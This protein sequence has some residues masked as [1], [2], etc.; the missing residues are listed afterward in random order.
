MFACICTSFYLPAL[1]TH[2]LAHKRYRNRFESHADKN[3]NQ[4]RADKI[5]KKT[6]K[7]FANNSQNEDTNPGGPAIG[8]TTAMHPRNSASP[9]RKERTTRTKSKRGRNEADFPIPGGGQALSATLNLRFPE[10]QSRKKQLGV[11]KIRMV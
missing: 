7:C 8:T 6:L 10:R 3:K 2:V 9:A 1:K 11:H 5:H 4:V